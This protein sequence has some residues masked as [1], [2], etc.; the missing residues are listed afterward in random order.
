[1]S[2]HPIPDG[3]LYF[4]EEKNG[5]NGHETQVSLSPSPG[6]S[7]DGDTREPPRAVRFA[8]ME[9]PKPR[10]YMVK[11]LIPE[12]YHTILYGDG[13]VAKSMLAMSLG[14]AVA[15]EDA[16]NWLGYE[17]QTA[18][19]LYLDFE[20]DDEEQNRRV[21]Q[22]CNAE[23]LSAPPDQLFYMAALGY[24]ARE[25]FD[26]ALAECLE[27]EVKLAVLDSMGPALGGDAESAKDVIAFFQQVLEDFRAAGVSVVIV[28][29]QAKGGGG[30]SYQSKR[31][32]GSV[33]KGNL[34]RSTIQA[35][36][37]E[38][39]EGSLTVR[40]RQNKH[41]FG[42]LAEPFGVKLGFT[43]EMVTTEAVELDATELAEETSLNSTD[44]VKLALEDGPAYPE[45]LVELTGLA[46]KTVKNALT[47][48][49]KNEVIQET[50]ETR[51]QSRQ[52]SLSLR[53]PRDGDRDT[54]G[55][56][57]P[58]GLWRER[59]GDIDAALKEY[60]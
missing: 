28:D 2:K 34:S 15:R 25:A 5:K 38:H 21:N 4:P 59:Q 57:D 20:L 33:Y 3:L 16:D 40:L 51:N 60:S 10:R 43:E 9:A 22:L 1:M 55:D 48:L 45:E 27:K 12:A 35:E 54:Y 29:H 24:G 37:M 13:G 19:V 36:A 52:V 18:P 53:I 44:R 50:G 30:E 32:F 11:G 47:K 14:L 7:G 6:F 42:S 31:A 17:A 39:E 58:N 46:S 23:G 49:R 41:N 8:D 26:A 56:G